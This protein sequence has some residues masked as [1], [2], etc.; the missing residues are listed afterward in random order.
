MN[1]IALAYL[2]YLVAGVL[3][4]AHDVSARLLQPELGYSNVTLHS[5]IMSAMVFLPYHNKPDD[6]QYYIGSRFEHGSMIGDIVFGADRTVYGRKMWR[7]P[8]DNS[9]PESGVG[10]A[11]EFGCGNNGPTCAGKG[12]IMNGVLGYDTAKIGEPFLKIG[13][14]ALVKG[15][16]PDCL[17]DVSGDYKFNS[18]YKFY[19]PPMWVTLPSPGPNE[20]SFVHEETLGDFGY[21]IQK[22]IR[23]EGNILTVRTILSNSG[24]KQF[25]T[26]WYSH[27]FFTGDNDSVGPGYVLDLGL[28]EYGVKQSTPLFDQPGVGIWAEDLNNYAN[29]TM[30]RDGSISI[31][32]TKPIPEGVKLKAEFLDEQ[33]ITLTDGSFTLHAP[34]GLAVEERIPELQSQS[35]NPFIYAYNLY[36]ERGTL[37]PEPMLLLYLQPGETTVWTQNL[38]FRSDD[39]R[40]EGPAQLF[41][42]MFLPSDGENVRFIPWRSA[43]TVA[44]CSAAFAGFYSVFIMIMSNRR[45]EAYSPIPDAV[46]V[47]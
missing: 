41:L 3:F 34:N 28:C 7:N 20:I 16:C 27:H 43:I 33:T 15:S 29:V 8:H 25:N 47:V 13:V 4:V 17:T 14:G 10:L 44:V 21:R 24:R 40:H 30:G 23:L 22:T 5:P 26:P 18:P 9:W 32:M 35:R 42:S 38:K 37:S 45:V 12:D 6:G 46:N 39:V 36:A 1:S 31:K 2:H 19:R 11:S